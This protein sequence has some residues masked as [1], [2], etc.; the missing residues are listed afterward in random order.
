MYVASP[1]AK[2]TMKQHYSMHCVPEQPV[3]ITSDASFI[4]L[5]RRY[6]MIALSIA[7]PLKYIEVPFTSIG[8]DLKS[9]KFKNNTNI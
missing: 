8:S 5:S 4:P 9:K 6:C 7:L 1:P 2:Q 3:S